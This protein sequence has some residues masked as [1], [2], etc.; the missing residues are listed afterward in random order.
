MFSVFLSGINLKLEVLCGY[1]FLLLWVIVR[2]LLISMLKLISWLFFVI[3][4]KL[5]L[6]VWIFI[7]FCG[8]MII[9]VLNLCG[10]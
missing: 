7:L 1:V 5:R 9:V 2:L 3:V 10:K 6:F 8:G 4:M